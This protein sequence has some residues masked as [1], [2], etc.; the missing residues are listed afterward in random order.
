MFRKYEVF[1]TKIFLGVVF[2]QQSKIIG[3]L[4]NNTVARGKNAIFTCII[5][6]LGGHRV[7]KWRFGK[8]IGSTIKNTKKSLAKNTNMLNL[9]TDNFMFNFIQFKIPFVFK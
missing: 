9:N 5:H 1:Q 2:G 3:V 8:I 7:H 6:N 4:K